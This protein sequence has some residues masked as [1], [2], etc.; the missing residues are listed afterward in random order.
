MLEL[1]RALIALRLDHPAALGASPGTAGQ[2]V[3]LDDETLAMRRSDAENVFWVVT[4]LRSAGVADLSAAVEAAG[5]GGA[6]WVV[7][8]TTEDPL[9]APDARPVNVD[10]RGG[11]LVRFARAG[12]VILRRT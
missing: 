9:F 2:A 1:Y 6:E 7:V 3:A 11:P 10:E 5:D 4:R 8:L 12:A